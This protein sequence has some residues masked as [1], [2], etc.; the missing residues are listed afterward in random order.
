M[1]KFK[2]EGKSYG[3]G[4]LLIPVQSQIISGEALYD[5]LKQ[6][7]ATAGVNFDP[8]STG[9]STEGI[10]LGSNSV[11][12]V[13]MPKAVMIVGAGVNPAESGEIWHLL[14]SRIGM[15]VTKID[16]SAIARVNLQ[17]YTHLIMVGGQYQLDRSFGQKLKT[18]AAAGGVVVSL[19]TGSEWLIKNGI[20]NEKLR[21]IKNDTS[22]TSIRTSFENY[23]NTIGAKQTNGSIF[24]TTLD[25][26]HPIG[27]GFESPQLM[28][29]RNNNTIME[30]S[31]V[32]ANSP[33]MYNAQPWI[34]GYVHP[35]TLK[36]IA[37]SAAVNVA[38]EGSG[39]FILFADNPN[40]RAT[41]YGTN[42]LFLNALF[43]GPLMSSGGFNN[44]N[45]EE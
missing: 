14:D 5:I 8:V 4:T 37:G 10:D 39:R 16:V 26:S 44:Q 18:F 36:K 6:V 41:W 29:Y 27:F 7:Q 13:K 34:C 25:L 32:S 33:L 35:E 22:R 20:V 19:K 9:F 2:I 38:N 3:Y 24:E 45:E 1:K 23:A 31:I 28:V 21:E 40:F 11:Q 42:K 17:N 12:A 15:P 43:F 30:R